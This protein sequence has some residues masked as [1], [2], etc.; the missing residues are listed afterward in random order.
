MPVVTPGL[1]LVAVHA[2]LHHR[3]FAVVGDEEAV[4]IEIETVLDRGAV[5]LGDEAAGA[6]QWCAVEAEMI[7]EHPKLVRRLS[8]VLAAAAA[9]MEAKF[10][11]H[12]LQAAF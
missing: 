8:R 7:A 10:M 12:R 9:D 2:L 11:L 6:D 3:P 5:D 1:P 4:Q